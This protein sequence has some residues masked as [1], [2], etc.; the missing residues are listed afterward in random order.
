MS[1]PLYIKV[2]DADNVA[3]AVHDIPRGTGVMPGVVTREDIPQ[4]HKI[5]LTDI[6]KGGE[7]VRYNALSSEVR[8]AV[9]DLAALKFEVLK[10]IGEA[11]GNDQAYQL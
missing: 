4:A 1:A 10:V 11:Y 6:P 2:K 9:S 8:A 7:V 3:I 5:A